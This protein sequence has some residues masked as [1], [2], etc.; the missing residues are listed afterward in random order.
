MMYKVVIRGYM[1]TNSWPLYASSAVKELTYTSRHFQKR[2]S[3]IIDGLSG[4]L[5]LIDGI[6]IMGKDQKECNKWLNTPLEW[7]QKAGVTLNAEKWDI[8]KRQ[9]TFL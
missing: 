3:T 4:V 6:L 5:C 9:V 8:S 2:M 1:Q 7:I